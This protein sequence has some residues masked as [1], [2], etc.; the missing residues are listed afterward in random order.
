MVKIDGQFY[1][2]TWGGILLG[3]GEQRLGDHF[4]TEEPAGT[5]CDGM[6]RLVGP[7]LETLRFNPF[8][9]AR[10]QP[11][12][13]YRR[14]PVGSADPRPFFSDM[15]PMGIYYNQAKGELLIFDGADDRP[16]VSDGD[17]YTNSSRMWYGT[18]ELLVSKDKGRTFSRGGRILEPPVRKS[19]WAQNYQDY[20]VYGITHPVATRSSDGQY[21]YLYLSWQDKDESGLAVARSKIE[22]SR[23]GRPGT[24]FY[25]RNGKWD[26]PGLG[27][28]P[29]ILIPRIN[30]FH[31][32]WNTYLNQYVL[33]G[34]WWGVPLAE[35]GYYF[36]TSLDGINWTSRG[37]FWKV[38]NDFD[39]PGLPPAVI[40]PTVFSPDSDWN[41]IT[42]RQNYLY[43]S[44]QPD[45]DNFDYRELRRRSLSFLVVP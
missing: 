44:Y 34:T 24:W 8:D 27:G 43:Y 15:W 20:G 25:Y 37:M 32:S 31:V 12:A 22:G 16:A 26:E 19:L 33:I 29:D 4:C 39:M 17:P 38:N 1:T 41:G 21:I 3:P 2:F 28:E 18:G 13:V 9:S 30:S 36:Y 7:T 42:T 11:I 23:T 14:P 40:F 10:G 5:R 6:A 35:R 45:V